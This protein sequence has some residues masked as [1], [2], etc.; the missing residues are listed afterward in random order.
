MKS[1]VSREFL[2]D[3]GKKNYDM[4]W[5]ISVDFVPINEIWNYSYKRQ[6]ITYLKKPY[7][8]FYCFLKDDSINATKLYNFI[9]L[10]GI[11]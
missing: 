2:T 10:P 6:G 1:V 9:H 4:I 7:T 3:F 8:F 11:H 5:Y